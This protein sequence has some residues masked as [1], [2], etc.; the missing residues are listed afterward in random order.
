MGIMSLDIIDSNNENIIGYIKI[1]PKM[2]LNRT[3]SGLKNAHTARFM[4]VHIRDVFTIKS[5]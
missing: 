4:D 5:Y 1:N 2:Y 3:N